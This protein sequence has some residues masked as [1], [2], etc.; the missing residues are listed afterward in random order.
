[1]E[2]EIKSEKDNEVLGRTEVSFEVDHPGDDTPSRGDIRDKLA[3]LKDSDDELIMVK[4]MD[5][6][7]GRPVTSGRADVY[8]EADRVE[9]VESDYV[10]KRNGVVEG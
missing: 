6:E 8:E 3:A 5:T 4:E 1:M 2:L 9:E 10:L 7:Y